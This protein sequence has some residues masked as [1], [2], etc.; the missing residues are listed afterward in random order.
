M[1]LSQR[2][3]RGWRSWRISTWDRT[4]GWGGQWLWMKGNWLGTN[5]RW[6]LRAIWRRSSLIGRTRARVR[7]RGVRRRDLCTW[8]EAV[9]AEPDAGFNRSFRGFSVGRLDPYACSSSAFASSAIENGVLV[10]SRCWV[11]FRDHLSDLF[12][13][14]CLSYKEVLYWVCPPILAPNPF[15]KTLL[16]LT[17][18]LSANDARR[19][20]CTVHPML[21]SRH[22]G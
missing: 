17:N 9:D 8:E 2:A 21:R 18:P 16:S 15:S 22:L 6:F 1:R 7:P 20:P 3:R 5:T 10:V 4:A 11:C 19:P 13:D 14:P 12:L